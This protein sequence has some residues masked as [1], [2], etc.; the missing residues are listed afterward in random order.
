MEMVDLQDEFAVLVARSV[1]SPW[2]E[3]RVHYENAE[4][5]G[6]PRE[7]FSASVLVNGAEQPL[8]RPLTL[9]LG[10]LDLLAK[11]QQQKPRGQSQKWV[12]AEFS[13]DKTGKYRFDYKYDDPPLIMEQLKHER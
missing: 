7:V 10:A 3:I 8:K 5:G 11:L 13:I 4:I 12:W 6:V 2:D 1:T 9:P